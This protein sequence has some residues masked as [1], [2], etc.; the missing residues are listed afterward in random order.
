[1]KMSETDKNKTI[2]SAKKGGNRCVAPGC[3]SGYDSNPK[4]EHVFLAPKGEENVK[5][6][7]KAIMRDDITLKSVH[8][9][10]ALHFSKEDILWQK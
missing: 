7:Q 10:C 1:M 5:K 4:K 2:K 8:K 3:T 9:V 6:W